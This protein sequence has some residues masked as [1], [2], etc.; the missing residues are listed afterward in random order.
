VACVP[1]VVVIA[2]DCSLPDTVI[3]PVLA[4]ALATCIPVNQRGVSYPCPCGAWQFF[5][6]LAGR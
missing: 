6:M 3:V 4:V 1:C 5:T 2:L